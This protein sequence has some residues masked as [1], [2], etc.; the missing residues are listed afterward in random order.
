MHVPRHKYG[1]RPS[2]EVRADLF[3][4]H[5]KRHPTVFFTLAILAGLPFGAHAQAYL[6]DNATATAQHN[7]QGEIY[8]EQEFFTTSSSLDEE[9]SRYRSARGSATGS[10][11]SA[12]RASSTRSVDGHLIA[13]AHRS[14]ATEFAESLLQVADREDERETGLG[15]RIR[16]IA[17]AEKEAEPA[18]TTAIERV[19]FRSTLSSFVFGSDHEHLRLLKNSLMKTEQRLADLAAIRESTIDSTTRAMLLTQI[20]RLKKDQDILQKFTT[21][22]E[23][24]FSFFGWVANLFS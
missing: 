5:M 8:R 16:I 18:A 2:L 24:R 12:E 10:E 19:A 4:T 23:N 1:E 20:E 15:E 17:Q 13:Q 11:I 21:A 9:V 6:T 3:C 7:G 22:H 14:A